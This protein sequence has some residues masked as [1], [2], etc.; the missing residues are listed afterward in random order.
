VGTL[1]LRHDQPFTP[2]LSFTHEPVPV[3]FPREHAKLLEDWELIV[4]DND[5]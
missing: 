2:I 1:L 3:R 5:A 4:N